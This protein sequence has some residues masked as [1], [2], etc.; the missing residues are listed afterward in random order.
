MFKPLNCP[1]YF[2]RHAIRVAAMLYGLRGFPPSAIDQGIGGE[3]GGRSRFVVQVLNEGLDSL[4]GILPGEFLHLFDALGAATRIARLA[5]D[6]GQGFRPLA[7]KVQR[8]RC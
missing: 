8:Q 4:L 1:N 2:D 6:K 7:I 3:D 5:L